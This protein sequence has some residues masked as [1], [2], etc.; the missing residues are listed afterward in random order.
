MRE[1]GEGPDE[2]EPAGRD[3]R[4]PDGGGRWTQL[5]TRRTAWRA[6]C[7]TPRCGFDL[8]RDE[9]ELAELTERSSD[10]NL[11]NDQAEAQSV[12][13]RAEE[14]RSGIAAWREL[15]ARATGLAEMA[16]LAAAD[17]D[18]AAA[19]QPDLDRDLAALQADWNRMEQ[20]LL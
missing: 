16:E 18:E 9:A 3:G 10:P 5:G 8:S 7:A 4:A 14:L 13:R 12:M 2:A 19:L 6:S 11:W 17:P 1:P 15:E 20:L